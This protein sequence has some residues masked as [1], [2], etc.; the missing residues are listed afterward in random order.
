MVCDS[1]ADN[2]VTRP[3]IERGG[4]EGVCE[5]SLNGQVSARP[6]GP[7]PAE[8]QVLICQARIK[9][10]IRV[11]V[12]DSAARINGPCLETCIGS[13]EC[14]GIHD[15]ATRQTHGVRAASGKQVSTGI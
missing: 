15:Q 8:C 11:R 1:P 2:D 9:S 5:C 13:C 3:E 14:G 7:G 6:G 4:R 10:R 12:L